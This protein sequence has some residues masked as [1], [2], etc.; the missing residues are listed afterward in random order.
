MD[1]FFDFITYL[2]KMPAW[3]VYGSGVAVLL[4]GLGLYFLDHR[5]G[6]S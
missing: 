3:L 4:C 1:L 5:A 2:D 6:R